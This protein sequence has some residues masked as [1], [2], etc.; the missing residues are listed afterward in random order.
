MHMF[1]AIHIGF[2]A[3]HLSCVWKELYVSNSAIRL[4]IY[5]IDWPTGHLEFISKNDVS[6]L[7]INPRY[8]YHMY[9]LIFLKETPSKEILKKTALCASRLPP[10]LCCPLGNGNVLNSI[11]QE[12]TGFPYLHDHHRKKSSTPHRN[13]IIGAPSLTSPVPS[14]P[15]PPA[16]R[17]TKC[18]NPYMN[19]TPPNWMLYPPFFQIHLI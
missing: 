8:Y 11:P 9:M 14:S 19:P 16:A 3:V 4:G 6:L 5:N 7:L 18:I 17:Q 2:Q 12:V 13:V 15:P 1:R 10:A